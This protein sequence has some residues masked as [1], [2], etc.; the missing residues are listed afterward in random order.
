MKNAGFDRTGT[1]YKTRIHNLEQ[2][3]KI[4]K[5]AVNQTGQERSGWTFFEDLDLKS[6][7]GLISFKEYAEVPEVPQDLT[8]EAKFVPNSTERALIT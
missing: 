1:Q 4:R 6:I 8:T 2:R 7:K 5:E 3:Y